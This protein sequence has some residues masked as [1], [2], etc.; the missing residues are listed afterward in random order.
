MTVK[1]HGRFLNR[2]KQRK[3]RSFRTA[4]VTAGNGR[5]RLQPSRLGLGRLRWSVALPSTTDALRLFRSLFSLFSPVQRNPVLRLPGDSV[6]WEKVTARQ[7]SRPTGFEGFHFQ[8]SALSALSRSRIPVR[9][10]RGDGTVSAPRGQVPLPQARRISLHRRSQRAQRFS[11]RRC[12]VFY[13]LNQGFTNLL[14]GESSGP[15]RRSPS[16]HES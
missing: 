11:I 8:I 7:E 15:R 12:P 3:Q 9:G 16:F 6:S 10:R 2:R 14:R 13:P 4:S 5:A 1:I